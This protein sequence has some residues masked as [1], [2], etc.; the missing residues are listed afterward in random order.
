VLAAFDA[1]ADEPAALQDL[2][3]ELGRPFTDTALSGLAEEDLAGRL[4][5]ARELALGLILEQDG[6]A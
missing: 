3:D 4:A 2:L 6:V 1:L 5:A